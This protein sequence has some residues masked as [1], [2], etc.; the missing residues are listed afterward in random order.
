MLSHGRQK[1]G[2]QETRGKPL[3]LGTIWSADDQAPISV[4][5]AHKGNS[6]QRR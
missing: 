4:F 3:R 1:L 2:G 6:E 5:A